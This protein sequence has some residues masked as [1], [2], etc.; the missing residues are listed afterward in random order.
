M[1]D[2]AKQILLLQ[3]LTA[4]RLGEIARLRWSEVDLETG[5]INLPGERTKN[6]QS[7]KIMLSTQAVKILEGRPR[8]GTFVFPGARNPKAPVRPEII[9]D[10]V[11]R[12][13]E[14]LGQRDT[15]IPHWL[16]HTALTMAASMK[17]SKDVRDRISN[18][19]D[20][21]IDGRYKHHEFDD[22]ARDCLQAIADRV[23]S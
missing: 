2:T 22:E 4:S 13:R 6:G 11:R 12:N 15:F 5:V 21:S 18:H 1:P 8:G 17:F 23:M 7:H 16:R 19:K 3:L 20:G 9:N 14:H 10:A